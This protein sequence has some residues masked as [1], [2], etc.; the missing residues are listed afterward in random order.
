MGTADSPDSITIAFPDATPAEAA[1]IAQELE[2]ELLTAGLAADSIR[3]ARTNDEAMD[4]GGAV[5]ILGGLGLTFLEEAVKG[6]GYEIG[7]A[8]GRKV[9]QKLPEAIENALDWICRRH[10]T[11][12]E[13]KG[14]DST[15][16]TIGRDYRRSLLPSGAPAGLGV[17]G[18]VILGAS[19]FPHMNDATLD[20]AAF[21][22]SAGKAK[23]LF[24]P[25]HTAF[26]KAEVLDLFDRD[27]QPFEVLDAIE[28]HIDAHPD[29]RDLL[30]YYCGHGSFQRDGTYFL[31]LHLPRFPSLEAFGRRPTGAWQRLRPASESLHMSCRIRLAMCP[32]AAVPL[33]PPQGGGVPN[34]L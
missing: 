8:V 33:E 25:P 31:M 20:N 15:T 19:Q 23:T 7:K 18:I 26:A 34:S 17:L 29:M 30:I 4:L 1:V 6:A 5:L 21:G 14:P 22:R 27:M 9:A 13:I 16:W 32:I 28:G 2:R 10:R 12:A 24:S 11:A 3:I